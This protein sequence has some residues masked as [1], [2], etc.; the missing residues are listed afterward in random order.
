MENVENMTGVRSPLG[1]ACADLT[2]RLLRDMVVSENAP[3]LR[4]GIDARVTYF[5]PSMERGIGNYTLNHLKTIF[6][7]H[8]ECKFYLFLDD[9]QENK[10]LTELLSFPNVSWCTFLSPPTIDLFHIPDPMSLIPGFDSPFLKAPKTPCTTT[11]YDLIPL[12]VGAW[13]FDR[14]D[15]LPQMA[16]KSR[17]EEMKRGQC[18]VLSISESTK[19]DLVSRCNFDPEKIFPIMAGLNRPNQERT[20]TQADSDATLTKFGLKKPFFISVGGLEGHKNFETTANAFITLKQHRDVQL[21]VVGGGSDPWKNIYKDALDKQG[22]KG[23][24]FTGFVSREDLCILYAA[25]SGLVFPSLYEGFGFPALEAMANGCPVV[26]SKTSS[27]PE[28]CGDAALYVEPKDVSAVAQAMLRLVDESGLRQRL[29]EVGKTQAQKFSWEKCAKLT[30][31]I[32]T[33]L[34]SKN[35]VAKDL[36]VTAP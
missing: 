27:L 30:F 9:Y 15:P 11:F 3:G 34:C 13:P 2:A 21:A 20:I 14:D 1:Q 18:T 35:S 10:Y 5:S 4:V 29:S 33:K 28:V 22:I 16:Y 24:V 8:P 17:L 36:S 7:N 12:T 32:W 25:A 31:E 26:V 23:V 19:R 6:K